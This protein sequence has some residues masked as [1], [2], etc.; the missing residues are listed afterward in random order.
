MSTDSK[1]SI[2]ERPSHHANSSATLFR[3][4]WEEPQETSFSN[5]QL[6]TAPGWPGL[7]FEWA[8]EFAQHSHKPVEVVQPTFGTERSDAVKATWL[9]H[10]VRC[11]LL[12]R[13]ARFL[14]LHLEFLGRITK[15][16]SQRN[17]Y[18]DPL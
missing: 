9:G 15:G 13:I 12:F 5:W 4:P 3:N 6:P 16:I 1:T 11:R 8:K 18:T 2:S 17:H 10:A 7:P 14:M